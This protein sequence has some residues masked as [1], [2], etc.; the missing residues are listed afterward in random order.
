MVASLYGALGQIKSKIKLL[1][2]LV[3]LTKETPE[4]ALRDRKHLPI[5]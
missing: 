3:R 5:Q 2:V 1:E 4:T